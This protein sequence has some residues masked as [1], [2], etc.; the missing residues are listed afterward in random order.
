MSIGPNSNGSFEI[1][2]GVKCVLNY[3]RPYRYVIETIGGTIIEGTATPN[4][5][6]EIT[7]GLDIK[8]IKIIIDE[9]QPIRL[10]K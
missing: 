1:K 10:V 7:P 5:P 3:K 4:T 8:D 9:E 6:L 2:S